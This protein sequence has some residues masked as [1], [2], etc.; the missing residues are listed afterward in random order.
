MKPFL[1]AHQFWT[2]RTSPQ[3]MPSDYK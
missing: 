2:V 3:V 1:S